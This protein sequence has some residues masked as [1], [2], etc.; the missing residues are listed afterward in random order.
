[1]SIPA[2]VFVVHVWTGE[3]AFRASAR[4]A[5]GE[6]ALEFVDPQRL[7]AFLNGESSPSIQATTQA[8]APPARAPRD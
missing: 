4:P 8:P 2:R 3:Q 6:R 5:D 7:L 1:M